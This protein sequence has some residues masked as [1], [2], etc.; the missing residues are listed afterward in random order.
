MKYILLPMLAVSVYAVSAQALSWDELISKPAHS[1]KSFFSPSAVQEPPAPSKPAESADLPLALPPAEAKAYLENAKPALLD[2]RTPE[3]YSAGHLAA[4]VVTDYYAP[5]FKD[6]LD[7][8]DKTAKYLIYCRSGKKS[9]ATLKIMRELGFTDIHDI[10][11]G[12]N[13]WV[14]AGYPVVQ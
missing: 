8:L 6:R 5:D 1:I 3:E 7:R 9:A 11:G 4:A 14:E 12:F 10:A 2:V 13:A